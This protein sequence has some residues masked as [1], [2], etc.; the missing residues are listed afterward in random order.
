MTKLGIVMPVYNHVLYTYRA[1]E[2][3]IENTASPFNLIMIDDGSTDDTHDYAMELSDLL[4][5][6]FYYGRNQKNE[7]VHYSWNAGLRVAF[8]QNSDY[9]AI[10]NNDVLFTK[11]WDLPLINALKTKK[12]VSPY[13]TDCSLP[14]DWPSGSRRIANQGNLP[15]LGACFMAQ[16]QTFRDVGFFPEQM[17]YYF[18]DNWLVRQV[19]EQQCAQVPD[20]YTHHYFSK[21][22]SELAND[23]WFKKDQEEYLRL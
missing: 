9:I 14:D 21:T 6:R 22:T 13:H 10:V 5:E 4:K 12:L 3:L 18:G 20:S 15:I 23:Y 16:T 17:R 19:G 2:S 1:V 8:D 7:G 11:N